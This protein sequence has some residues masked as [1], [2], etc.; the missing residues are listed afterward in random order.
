MKAL[1]HSRKKINIGIL[2]KEDPDEH[3]KILVERCNQGN[4][5]HLKYY[6]PITNSALTSIIEKLKNAQY[7][8]T[9]DLNLHS[10]ER[11]NC[12]QIKLMYFV[13]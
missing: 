9:F 8:N 10:L 6:A 7:L 12:I 4:E 1:L 13:N 5:L 3:I 2:Y 11:I